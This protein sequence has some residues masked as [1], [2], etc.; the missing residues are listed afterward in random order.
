MQTTRS[1]LLPTALAVLLVLS[2]GAIERAKAQSNRSVSTNSGP[3]VDQ[4]FDEARQKG[5]E[6]DAA[7]WP[8]RGRFTLSPRFTKAYVD[9]NKRLWNDYGIFYQYTPTVMMQKGSQGGGQDFTANEQYSSIFGW[10]LLNKT[11]I[12]TGYFVF[13]NLHVGQLTKT[14]GGVFSQSLGINYFNSD[15]PGDVDVIKALL[16]RHEL[17]GEFLTINVGHD[18]IGDLDGGCRYA[19]DDTTAFISQPLSNNA[20]RTLPGQGAMLSA[21]IKLTDRVTVEVGAADAQGDGSLNS[22]RVFRT[23]DLAYAAALKFEN[24]F[25][26]VGDGHYKIS[27]YKVDPTRQ[28]TPAAQSSTQGVSIQIDQ[29]FG[30]LGVF[31]KFHQAFERKGS[32]ERSAAAGIVWT[33]PFGNNEDR[34]GLG[35]GWVDPTAPRTKNEYVAETYYRLQL[36]PFV[37][38]SAGAMLT[39]NPSNPDSSDEAVFTLRTRGQF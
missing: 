29:D 31:A 24:P 26:A 37:Q 18:S 22:R 20:A 19:C 30:D 7:G 1:S 23:G 33:A 13:S 14:S 11:R 35:L 5:D 16:W 28:G 17:P 8:P 32:I 27:Y 21:D 15:S 39:I 12:G 2:G 10:R 9:F 38:V 25:K 6:F 36:T 34:L 3:S 4:L